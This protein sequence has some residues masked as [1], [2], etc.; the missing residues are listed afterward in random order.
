MSDTSRIEAIRQ[1]AANERKWREAEP[2]M[3]MGQEEFIE[4]QA[5][6]SMSLDDIEWLLAEVAKARALT[7]R[8]ERKT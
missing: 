2:R 7:G 4:R 6:R 3:K 1:R 8:K 5:F